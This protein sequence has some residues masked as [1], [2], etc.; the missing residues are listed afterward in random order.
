MT[1]SRIP[2]SGGNVEGVRAGRVAG[3]RWSSQQKRNQLN[4][5]TLM[6]AL[7]RLDAEEARKAPRRESVGPYHEKEAATSTVAEW[8]NRFMARGI[9]AEEGRNLSSPLNDRQIACVSG[10]PSGAERV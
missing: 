8:N 4:R 6:A 1:A 9:I 10:Q 7:I 3:N 5:P 2:T